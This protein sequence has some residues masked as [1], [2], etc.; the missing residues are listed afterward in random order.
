[1]LATVSSVTEKDGALCVLSFLP[2]LPVLLATH[3]P[4]S[5]W[6]STRL[7]A[8]NLEQDVRALV[9]ADRRGLGNPKGK[10][11]RTKG[12]SKSHWVFSGC[13]WSGEVLLCE[14]NSYTDHIYHLD[15][16]W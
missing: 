16:G 1:M 12:N 6:G 3:P 5:A 11:H 4:D 9:N 2:L 15:R 13:H 8:E 7:D 10:W 14:G